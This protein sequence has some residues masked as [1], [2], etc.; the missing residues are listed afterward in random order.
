MRRIAAAALSLVTVLGFG[1]GGMRAFAAADRPSDSTLAAMSRDYYSF[2]ELDSELMSFSEYYD[3]YSARER[4]DDVITI[5]GDSFSS[6]SADG[7]SSGSFTDDP[8]QTKENVLI[9]SDAE[10]EV[11]YSFEVKKAGNYCLAVDYCPLVSASSSIE[12][13]AEIDGRVPYDTASRL[14]LGRVWVNEREIY[15]DMRG[16]QVR[17]VQVGASLWQSCFFGDVDGLFS[18]PLFFDLEEG[19]HELRLS[20]ERAQLAIA[21]LRF[22]Q[23][24]ELPSYSEYA[25]SAGS[26]ASVGDTPSA[27]IRIEGE[28]AAYKSDPTLY[29]TYDNSSYLASPS[30]PCKM[31]Y[32]TIGSGNW[33]RRSRP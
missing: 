32:N 33:K 17:P 18:E 20:S 8:G 30:D 25:A 5:S 3:T 13:K 4:P 1:T 28:K 2:G 22:C 9:W 12:L 6:S 16:N 23:P 14:T 29:P 15:T 31:V 27:L 19:R 24:E 10:G 21:E 26:T 7:M 11:T